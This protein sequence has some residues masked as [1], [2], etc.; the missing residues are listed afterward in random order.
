MFVWIVTTGPH[1][2]VRAYWPCLLQCERQ[3]ATIIM[4]ISISSDTP[5]DSVMFIMQVIIS[6]D[7][8]VFLL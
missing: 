6:A 5:H 1:V 7:T 8:P 2:D 3:T 4:Q